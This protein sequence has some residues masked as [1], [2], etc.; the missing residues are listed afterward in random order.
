VEEIT[1]QLPD[2]D[3]WIAR[4]PDG[5]IRRISPSEISQRI[6]QAVADKM[7]ET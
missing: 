1:L 7:I 3:K 5:R 6:A 4:L 2:V